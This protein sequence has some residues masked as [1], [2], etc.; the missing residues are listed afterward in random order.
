MGL[1]PGKRFIGTGHSGMHASETILVT[2]H[3]MIF[4][5]M[6]ELINVHL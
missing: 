4:S 5:E 1:S 2:V 3:R 6:S